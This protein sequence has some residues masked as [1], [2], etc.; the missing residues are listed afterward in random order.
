M[1]RREFITVVSAAIAMPLAVYAQN[2][3]GIPR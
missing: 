1:K 2:G 3:T